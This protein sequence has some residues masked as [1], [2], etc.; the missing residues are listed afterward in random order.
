MYVS[1]PSTF[2]RNSLTRVAKALVVGDYVYIDGGEF[3]TYDN[4]KVQHEFCKCIND[5][6][7]EEDY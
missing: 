1:Q 5:D 4:G 7:L 6:S 2:S 3:A